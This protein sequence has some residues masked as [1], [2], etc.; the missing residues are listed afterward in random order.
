MSEFGALVRN[1]VQEQAA[2]AVPDVVMLYANCA[3]DFVFH[4]GGFPD[5]GFKNKDP[6]SDPLQASA[7][8]IDPKLDVMT[9]NDVLGAPREADFWRN[10]TKFVTEDV[11][12]NVQ[13]ADGFRY[14]YRNRDKF[15]LKH[16]VRLNYV[17]E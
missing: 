16:G 4:V 12:R 15:S 14:T 1:A 17:C 6:T 10:L 2:S 7:S 8:K 11:V 5:A 13:M 9:A 3:P